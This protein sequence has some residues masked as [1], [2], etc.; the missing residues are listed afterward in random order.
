MF[1]FPFW[2]EATP[3]VNNHAFA[4]SHAA[5]PLKTNLLQ[6]HPKIL[7]KMILFANSKVNVIYYILL[8]LGQDHFV[9][10]K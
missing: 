6:V 8:F 10:G 2:Y 3:P 1:F 9:A 5:A 7:F 4:E